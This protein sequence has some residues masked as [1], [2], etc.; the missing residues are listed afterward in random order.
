MQE[1]EKFWHPISDWRMDIDID[2]SIT[3]RSVKKSILDMDG[4]A[5]ED[6]LKTHGIDIQMCTDTLPWTM[7]A[8]IFV[9]VTNKKT[10]SIN[11]FRA[12]L[13]TIFVFEKHW[14]CYVT[15]I[16]QPDFGSTKVI[17]DNNSKK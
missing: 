16:C 14:Q 4:A 5:R 13:Q 12:M 10:C 3:F 7:I 1:K 11:T 15:P 8:F 6:L 2:N 9:F 17:V